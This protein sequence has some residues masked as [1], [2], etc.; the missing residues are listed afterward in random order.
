M[1]IDSLACQILCQFPNIHRFIDAIN[2]TGSLTQPEG[3]IEGIIQI[4]LSTLAAWSTRWDATGRHGQPGAFIST[5]SG[6]PTAGTL[7]LGPIP[8]STAPRE[9]A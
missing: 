6:T 5:S 9:L 3:A 2:P 8:S 7:H 1:N 4:V